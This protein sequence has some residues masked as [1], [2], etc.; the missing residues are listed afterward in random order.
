MKSFDR[1]LNQLR[2]HLRGFKE[3]KFTNVF[4]P[5]TI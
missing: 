3:N 4:Y 5:E 1:G 2:K